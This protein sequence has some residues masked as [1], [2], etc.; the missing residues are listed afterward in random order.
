MYSYSKKNKWF[1]GEIFSNIGDEP[2]SSIYAL[3]IQ[4]EH[5][6]RLSKARSVL[7]TDQ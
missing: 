7:S 3:I 2:I 1:I 5:I 6:Q 4:E